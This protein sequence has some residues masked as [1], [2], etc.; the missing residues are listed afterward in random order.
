MRDERAGV[1]VPVPQRGHSDAVTALAI[2][3]DGSR[4]LTASQDSTLRVWEA[5]GRMPRLLDI[6]GGHM[7]GVG[8]MALA[9]DGRRLVSG[10]GDGVVRFHD[11]VDAAVIGSPGPTPHG[12]GVI[13]AGWIPGGAVTLDRGGLAMRWALEGGS[14]R[15]SRLSERTIVAMATAERGDVAAVATGDD[16]GRV[17]I[18]GAAGAVVFD[19]GTSASGVRSI[20]I[21]VDGRYVAIGEREGRMAIWELARGEAP[22]V[23][24]EDGGAGEVVLIAGLDA[25]RVVFARGGEVDW[26][27]GRSSKAVVKWAG[28]FE[29]PIA[30]LSVARDGSTIAAWTDAGEVRVWR[31]SGTDEPRQLAIDAAGTRTAV[32]ADDGSVLLAGGGDGSVRRYELAGDRGREVAQVPGAGGKIRVVRAAPDGGSLAWVTAP[33]GDAFVWHLESERGP[34]RIPG[35]WNA[36]A[37]VPGMREMLVAGRTEDG[38]ELAVV[39]PVTGRKRGGTFERPLSRD[40]QTRMRLAW[41]LLAVSPDGT[42]VA[43]AP[44]AGQQEIVCVWPIA[45]GE[46]R[47]VVGHRRTITG[48]DFATSRDGKTHLLTASEDGTARVWDVDDLSRPVAIHTTPGGLP[49]TAASLDSSDGMGVAVSLRVSA[50]ESRVAWIR[51]GGGAGQASE[52]ETLGSVDGRILALELSPDGRTLA[53]AG[54]SRAIGLWRRD[55]TGAGAWKSIRWPGL[56]AEDVPSEQTQSVTFCTRQGRDRVVA[57]G[58]DGL[59]RLAEVDGEGLSARAVGTLAVG[60]GLVSETGAGMPAWVAYTPEGVFDGSI[61]ADQT[62]ALR[63]GSELVPLEGSAGGFRQDGLVHAMFSGEAIRPPVYMDPLPIVLERRE[64]DAVGVA[65]LVLRLPPASGW[66][67]ARLYQNGTPVVI[68]DAVG[69]RSEVVAKAR[70]LPGENRFFAMAGRAGDLDSRS[71]ELLVTGALDPLPGKVHVLALGVGQAVENQAARPQR[72]E[73]ARAIATRVEALA[74]D[75]GR[76]GQVEILLNEHVNEL[77]LEQAFG[78]LRAATSGRPEDVVLVY[79]AAPGVVR[80]EPG[81]LGGPSRFAILGA[82]GAGRTVEIPYYAIERDL[83]HLD[84]L[85]RLVIVDAAGA[86]GIGN[87]PG[88]RLVERA[89]RKEAERSKTSYVSYAGEGPETRPAE[90][91]HLHSPLAFG[92]LAAL[93]TNGLEW[94]EGV[95]GARGADK[96]G[97]G[98]LSTGELRGYLARVIP[99]LVAQGSPASNGAT[100]IEGEVVEFPLLRIRW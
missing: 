54:Q 48:L 11:L 91:G 39:D 76:L 49:I 28:A 53:A 73:D 92:V 1:P 62:L 51:A 52:I 67:E 34:R 58:D 18:H 63:V 8:A 50:V 30:G 46:P 22:R 57:A 90:P 94:P 6:R 5:A 10:D 44:P 14:A 21:S 16:A 64:G 35:R 61:R 15:A 12:E 33:A 4:F 95:E 98:I 17:L 47:V 41:Q 9:S 93:G 13:A 38:G 77:E 27:S 83:L 7:I 96:D 19:L 23:V 100:E 65:E 71:G 20:A 81:A 60:L 79:L 99:R 69:S 31:R 37:F 82:P 87:D 56:R 40:G 25:D 72:A 89:L 43:A 26:V 88:V 45:G 85:G 84:A 24:F 59:V 97:N 36:L 66:T 74:K 86:R 78:R 80:P 70:L 75:S 42:W 3:A 68:A 55:P 29:E 2:S 32:L